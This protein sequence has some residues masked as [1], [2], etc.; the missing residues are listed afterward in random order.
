MDERP[1]TC[2]HLDRVDGVCPSCGDCTH[3]VVLNGACFHCGSTDL[4]AIAR[5]PKPAGDFVPAT[6][7]GKPREDDR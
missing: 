4:D 5:S 1:A 7:L 3:E 2:P 6:R